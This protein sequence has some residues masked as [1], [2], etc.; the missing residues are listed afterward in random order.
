MDFSINYKSKN[1]ILDVKKCNSL[2]KIF[3]LTFTGKQKAKA[4]LF[5]LKKPLAIH[6]FFVFFPFIAI[7]LNNGK[8]IEIQKVKPFRFHIKPKKQFNQLIEIPINKKYEKIVE[9]FWKFRGLNY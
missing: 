3:G 9:L 8:I 6:S 2:Q 4:L 1:I 7:W 5:D